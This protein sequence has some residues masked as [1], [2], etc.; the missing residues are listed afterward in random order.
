MIQ[1]L[2]LTMMDPAAGADEE[3]NDWANTEHIPERVRTPGFLTARRYRN[4]GSSPR[5]M[6]LYDLESLAVLQ[7]S[8]YKA[9]SGDRLSPWS[10]RILAG[11]SARW[12]FEGECISHGKDSAAPNAIARPYLLLFAWRGLQER[13]DDSLLRSSETVFKA[14]DND[15]HAR[16]YRGEREGRLDYLVLAEAQQPFVSACLE[17][18]RQINVP[19]PCEL[20]TVFTP[21][22]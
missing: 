17:A 10:K 3:F 14:A 15:C 7:S 6:S 21:Y 2:L 20:V 8:A 19:Q 5:Y 9:I 12:R 4:T 18:A 22:A 16:V 13:C 1:A 11:A